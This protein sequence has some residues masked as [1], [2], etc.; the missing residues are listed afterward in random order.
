MI[1]VCDVCQSPIPDDPHSLHSSF[2]LVEDNKTFRSPMVKQLAT[3]IDLCK[4]HST[5]IREVLK[6]WR[7]NFRGMMIDEKKQGSLIVTNID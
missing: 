5:K 7:M 4:E 1:R 2:F 6:A 3:G